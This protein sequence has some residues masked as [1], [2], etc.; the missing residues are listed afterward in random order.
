MF[1]L[2]RQNHRF[3]AVE[4]RDHSIYRPHGFQAARELGLTH[5]FSYGPHWHD[6]PEL[7]D[8]IWT[9]GNA[10]ESA[11]AEVVGGLDIDGGTWLA[12]HRRTGVYCRILTETPDDPEFVSPRG[13]PIDCATAESAREAVRLLETRLRPAL[14][15]SGKRMPGFHMLVADP[16]D[17]FVVAFDGADSV[18]ATALPDGRPHVLTESGPAADDESGKR[19]QSLAESAAAPDEKL[20]S[21]A[22]W[23]TLFASRPDDAPDYSTENWVASA[24]STIRPPYRDTEDRNR[25]KNVALF[26]VTDPSQA[27][28]TK[29]VSIYSA[30]KTGAELFAYNERQLFDYQPLPSDV[31]RV[32]FPTTPDDFFVV[33]ANENS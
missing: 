8:R 13:L 33:I 31:R 26:P 21:W 12:L 20:T 14:E 9:I 2:D 17:A 28:W 1:L 30:G 10:T 25:H 27:A 7:R 6:N 24:H 11:S 29:S 16:R 15:E 5:R 32:G 4:S 23:L 18:T 22:P 3:V 19:L